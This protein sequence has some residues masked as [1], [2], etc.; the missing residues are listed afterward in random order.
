MLGMLFG[1]TFSDDLWDDEPAP[2]EYHAAEGDD[3]RVADMISE[4]LESSDARK[5]AYLLNIYKTTGKLRGYGALPTCR[6]AAGAYWLIINNDGSIIALLGPGADD[7]RHD[8]VSGTT[9]HLAS[10]G[11][12]YAVW[13]TPRSR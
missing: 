8:Y 1:D 6:D 13:F 5:A 9:G 10:Y 3:S 11:G 4:L 2:I 12:K 7:N